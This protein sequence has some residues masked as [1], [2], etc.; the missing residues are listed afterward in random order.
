MG[1]LSLTEL[2]RPKRGADHQPHFSVLLRMGWSCTAASQVVTC[3]F[4]C[5]A[6]IGRFR[7][8]CLRVGGCVRGYVRALHVTDSRVIRNVSLRG[9]TSRPH[10]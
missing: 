1:T 6:F 4:I 3:T 8:F 7:V 5:V 2:K 9:H 10:C